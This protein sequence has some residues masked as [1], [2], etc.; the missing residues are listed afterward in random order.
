MWRL[1]TLLAALV[2]LSACAPIKAIQT[3]Q[4]LNSLQGEYDGIVRTEAACKT[5]AKVPETCLGDFTSLY[6][7]IESQ[8]GEAIH[9]RGSGGT[10]SEQQITIA[11]YRLAAFAAL[12]S[13]SGK[14]ADYADNGVTLCESVKVK[15]PRDCALLQVAG[16]YEIVDRYAADVDCLKAGGR[17]CRRSFEK[18][19]TDFC[20]NVYTPL[21]KATNKAKTTALLPAPVTDYMNRQLDL[22][23]ESQKALAAALTKNIRVADQP[24]E[25][26]EC[27]RLDPNDP[28]FHELCG[29]VTREP[30][31]TFKAECV[32]RTLKE[33]KPCPSM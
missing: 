23:R 21:L 1:L 28:H 32:R 15:P 14:A 24:R 30:M 4:T 20:P 22:A 26:C 19:A 29:T 27:I 18:A 25:P 17:D 12:K 11:L 7:S 10:L 31:A 8:A 2:A 16:H 33:E 9:A 6:A 5:T 13:K 3:T